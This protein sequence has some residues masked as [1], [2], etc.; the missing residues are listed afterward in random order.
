MLTFA[1]RIFGVARYPPVPSDGEIQRE[2]KKKRAC[3][4]SVDSLVGAGAGLMRVPF[5]LAA[6]AHG[7]YTLDLS[8]DETTGT[9]LVSNVPAIIDYTPVNGT[10]TVS[11]VPEPAMIGIGL[12]SLCGIAFRRHRKIA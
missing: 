8:T 12:M 6:G 7:I 3:E 10:I 5:T 1:G 2:W 4:Q 11:S 9:L